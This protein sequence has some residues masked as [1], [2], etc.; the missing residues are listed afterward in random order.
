MLRWLSPG[1]GWP[2]LIGLLFFRIALP[3][4]GGYHLERAGMQLHDDVG[5]DCKKGATTENQA[6]NGKYMG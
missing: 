3:C 5:I 4:S 1:E 6:A 2:F